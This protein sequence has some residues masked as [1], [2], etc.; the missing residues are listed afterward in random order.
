ML[1]LLST[2]RSFA[3][4]FLGKTGKPD[5]VDTATRMAKYADFSGKGEPSTPKR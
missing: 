1:K 3:N 4:A 2:L 5:P